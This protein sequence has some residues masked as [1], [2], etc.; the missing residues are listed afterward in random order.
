M[1]AQSETCVAK[2]LATINSICGS[3]AF[4]TGNEHCSKK[5]VILPIWN[6]HTGT[7]CLSHRCQRGTKWLEKCQVQTSINSALQYFSTWQTLPKQLQTS[8]DDALCCRRTKQ[9]KAAKDNPAERGGESLVTS[10]LGAILRDRGIE[11]DVLFIIFVEVGR[12]KFACQ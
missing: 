8:C 5:N 6:V 1:N 4:V 11:Y 2:Q 12:V 10:K 9:T 7:G 3:H